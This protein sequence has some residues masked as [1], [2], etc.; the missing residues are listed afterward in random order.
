MRIGP[1]EFPYEAIQ[2]DW[3]VKVIAPDFVMSTSRGASRHQHGRHYANQHGSHNAS[4][5]Q[6]PAEHEHATLYASGFRRRSP[7]IG[8]HVQRNAL[9]G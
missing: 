1:D 8:L 4:S 9:L 2:N 7:C 6:T 5:R 3:M